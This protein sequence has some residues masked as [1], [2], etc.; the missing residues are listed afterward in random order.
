MTE[1]KTEELVELLKQARDELWVLAAYVGQPDAVRAGLDLKT[2][3]KCQKIVHD[4]IV[5]ALKKH[6]KPVEKPKDDPFRP[7]FQRAHI[8]G[9]CVDIA[10]HED[11]AYLYYLYEQHPTRGWECSGQGAAD[12]EE[13][14]KM[15]A[16]RAAEEVA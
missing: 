5:A 4:R 8:N 9:R 14:C 11:G 12:S 3:A 6:S 2:T 16:I 7:Q 10:R 15:L 13:A 1:N